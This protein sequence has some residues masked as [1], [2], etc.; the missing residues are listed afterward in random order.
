MKTICFLL[1]L[2]L[3]A[4]FYAQT[5]NVWNGK[6]CAVV[7]T[8]DD[9]IDQHLD[10]AIPVLDSLGLKATLYHCLLSFCSATHK[11]METIICKWT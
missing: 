1:A 10:N 4:T 5:N 2:L 7:L 3:P 9:A 11:R 6:K 8:Y